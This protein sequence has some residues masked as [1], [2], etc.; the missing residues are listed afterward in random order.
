MTRV[1]IAIEDRRYAAALRDL[2]LADGKHRVLVLD[3]PSP[4]V[5]GVAVVDENILYRLAGTHRIDLSR[6]IIFLRRTEYDANELFE[7][8]VRH[9]IHAGAP[10]EVA[11]LIVL[12][13][14]RSEE[15]ENE[16]RPSPENKSIFNAEDRLF[17][18]ALRI[19]DR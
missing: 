17:L 5:E 7:A 16:S 14:E 11:R 10:P 15:A 13:A 6:Y 2:L 4:A 12:G 1:Q 3:Y 9:V 19:N 18:Q 8:G